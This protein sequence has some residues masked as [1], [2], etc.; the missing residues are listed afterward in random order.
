MAP[1]LKLPKD[2]ASF[3][4]GGTGFPGECVQHAAKPATSVKKTGQV[5]TKCGSRPVH[6]VE[7]DS[8]ADDS[9]ARGKVGSVTL[10]RIN[11]VDS[12]GRAKMRVHGKFMNFLRD[13]GANASLISTHDA[14]PNKPLVLQCDASKDGLGAALRQEKRPIAYASPALSTAERNY[15]HK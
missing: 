8:D 13:T 15:T 5:A 6:Q 2:V 1:K 12:T 7:A 14:D 3:V 11:A 4:A 9:H 10:H